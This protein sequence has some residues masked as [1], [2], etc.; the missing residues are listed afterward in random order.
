MWKYEVLQIYLKE[1]PD[2]KLAEAVAE[3]L[4]EALWLSYKMKWL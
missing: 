2:P 1:S 3:A 4:A